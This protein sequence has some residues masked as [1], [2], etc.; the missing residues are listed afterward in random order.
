MKSDSDY[1]G[2]IINQV[3]KFPEDI[4]IQRREKYRDFQ[5]NDDQKQEEK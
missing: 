1:L 4:A 3:Q 2:Y 5:E